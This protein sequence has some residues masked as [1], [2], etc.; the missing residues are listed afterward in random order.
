MGRTHITLIWQIAVQQG[1]NAIPFASAC[2]GPEC[3]PPLLISGCLG[4]YQHL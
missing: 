4:A 2:P 3:R 1:V